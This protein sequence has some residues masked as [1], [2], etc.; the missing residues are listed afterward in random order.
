MR[1][2]AA[3]VLITLLTGCQTTEDRIAADDRRC[4]SYGTKPGDPAYVQCRMGLDN[5]RAMVESS[6]R[7]GRGPGLIRTIQGQTSSY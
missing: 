4:Q 1:Q 7:L 2:I 6:E 5:N 3:L